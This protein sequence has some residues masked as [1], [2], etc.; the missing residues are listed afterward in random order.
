MLVVGFEPTIRMFEL[1][2]TIHALDHAAIVITI[3]VIYYNLSR[4]TQKGTLPV[5]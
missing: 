3:S 1:A 5:F 2:K 4:P